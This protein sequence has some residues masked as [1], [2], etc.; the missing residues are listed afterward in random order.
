MKK[1]LVYSRYF[2]EA[3]A[4]GNMPLLITALRFALQKKHPANDVVIKNPK[5]GTVVCRKNTTDFMFSFYAYEY[6][7]KE[8]LMK[9]K[10][11]YTH[12][13]DIG[14]CIGDYSLLMAKN[15]MKVVAF[16][17][18]EENHLQLQKNIEIN[19]LN[20]NIETK[21]LALGKEAGS[22]V[23]NVREDNKGASS[24]DN[25]Y[26]SAYTYTVE[27]DTLD[28]IGSSLG[29]IENC[30]LKIDAE[31]MEVEVLLGANSFIKNL[32]KALIII[33]VTLTQRTEIE[34]ILKGYDNYTVVP[35]DEFNMGIF[36]N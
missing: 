26:K 19:G 11:N 8:F 14:A 18:I 2:T 33:E 28:T 17:P 34:A 27:V 32:K 31:G 23:F 10:N 6:S 13:L 29:E 4:M 5:M 7:V 16:E 24:R 21:K 30:I 15:G 1:L 35:I 36:I 20:K 9:H 3:I 25:A 22:T 12:F